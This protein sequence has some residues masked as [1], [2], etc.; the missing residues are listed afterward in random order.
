M[1]LFQWSSEV[2]E[3]YMIPWRLLKD[4]A[5]VVSFAAVVENAERDPN[6]IFTGIGG[7]IDFGIRLIAENSF[8]GR[9]LKID[10]SGDGRSN[11]G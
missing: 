6:R 4:P 7:A 3:Q 9:R 10:I 5:S 1:A 2:D 11:Y 8:E